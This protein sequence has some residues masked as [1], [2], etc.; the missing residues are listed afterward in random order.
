[1]GYCGR[2]AA[3]RRLGPQRDLATVALPVLFGL[4]AWRRG[5]RRGLLLLLALLAPAFWLLHDELL[6]GS[7]LFSMHIPSAYTD[8]YPPGR[9]VIPL[10]RWVRRFLRSYSH[11]RAA[12]LMTTSAALGAV[13]LLLRRRALGLVLAAGVLFVGVWALLGRY[14]A[15]G[16]YISP[17]FFLLPNLALR[18]LAVFGLAVPLDLLVGRLGK[19]RRVMRLGIAGLCVM[20][21][22]V[23]LSFLLW[24]LTPV[25]DA[26]RMARENGTRRSQIAAVA[27]QALGPVAD[28][29][30]TVLLVPSLIRNRIAVEL[31][32]PLTR[33]RDDLLTVK[34]RKGQRFGQQ[35][36]RAL[37]SVD[38]VVIDAQDAR[39]APLAVSAPTRFGADMVVPLRVDQSIGVYVLQV[40][41]SRAEDVATTTTARESTSPAPDAVVRAPLTS[42][43]WRFDSD[44]LEGDVV[45][46]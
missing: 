30:G 11:D 21:G 20:I 22:A 9:R 13:F 5:D 3:P 37:P 1:M 33:V 6:S 42:I 44:A 38:A 34:V 8:A 43:A 23:A 41:H 4:L 19:E 25:D 17:R 18:G 10:Q 39:Y 40:R 29:N 31:D 27:V 12:T 26:Y 16:V 32:L 46:E 14:A 36:V 45:H 2:R 35:L 28:E 7:A 24:P 15:E